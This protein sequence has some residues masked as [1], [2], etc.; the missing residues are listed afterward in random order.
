M[1]PRGRIL[2]PRGLHRK[3]PSLPWIRFSASRGSDIVTAHLVAMLLGFVVM[4]LFVTLFSGSSI[5]I[6][7][8][9]TPSVIIRRAR[10]H[11]VVI[12]LARLAY[13][14]RIVAI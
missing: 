13:A 1:L 2:G 10:L 6:I 11:R 12:F 4:V 8:C 7:S 9:Q 14:V 3:D 5:P